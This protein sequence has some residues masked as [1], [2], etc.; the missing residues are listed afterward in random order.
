M[1]EWS[2]TDV[3][4][5]SINFPL[6]FYQLLRYFSLFSFFFFF[7]LLKSRMVLAAKK[8]HLVTHTK[9]K[10]TR[11]ARRM[12]YGK[13]TRQ[14]R[15]SIFF[16]LEDLRR[17]WGVFPHSRCAVV[18]RYKDRPN[19]NITKIMKM[20]CVIPYVKDK[21]GLFLVFEI[22]PIFHYKIKMNDFKIPV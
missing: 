4:L 12:K 15:E 9:S 18:L 2:F 20:I 3:P 7:L 19:K 10:L 14:P 6:H 8:Q 11:E 13:T 21:F 16:L 5:H 17:L 22:Q 1:I